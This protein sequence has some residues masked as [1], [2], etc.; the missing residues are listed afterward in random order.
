MHKL[1]EPSAEDKAAWEKSVHLLQELLQ[2]KMPMASK[3][4]GPNKIE[5]SQAEYFAR[6]G[7]HH[8]GEDVQYRKTREMRVGG[9]FRFGGGHL[10]EIVSLL[11]GAKVRFDSIEEAEQTLTEVLGTKR[12]LVLGDDVGTLS[13]ILKYFG[14]DAYGVEIYEE[15]VRFAHIG[16][17]AENGQPSTQV[18][19]G[20]I[21]DIANEHSRLRQTLS[22]K[23][24][25][26][27]ITSNGVLTRDVGLREG[28]WYIEGTEPLLAENGYQLHLSTDFNLGGLITGEGGVHRYNDKFIQDIQSEEI[29]SAIAHGYWD[30]PSYGGGVLYRKGVLPRVKNLLRERHT[31]SSEAS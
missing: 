14:A 21:R 30:Y 22:A 19:Q 27:L 12:I 11:K 7:R 29:Q 24:P 25:F 2:Q 9:A 20:D 13:N 10:L 18:I 15:A 16:L 31:S 26:D 4:V 6:F 5:S 1:D 3:Q 28:Y 17:F 23:A 8:P